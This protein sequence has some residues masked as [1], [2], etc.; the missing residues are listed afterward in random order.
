MAAYTSKN[1]GV[2]DAEGESTWNEAG[3]PTAGDTVTI[4]NGHTVTLDSASACTTLTIDAGGV[5]TDATNNQ[6]L[7]VSG[8]TI[9]N[10]TLTCG[11]GAMSFG[12]GITASFAIT[13]NSGGT[14]TGGSGT[15]VIGSIYNNTGTLT[16][17]SGTTTID[18]ALVANDLS[19]ALNSGTFNHSDGTVT[20]TMADDQLLFDTNNTAR[21]F[22]NL[23]VN[24]AAGHFQFE[25]G[26][27]YHLTVA[28]DL[29]ITAGEFDTKETVS[30]TS[31][32]LTVVGKTIVS[33]TLT[34]NASTISLGS[35]KTQLVP[36]LDIK[37]GGTFNG[38]SGTHT[39]GNVESI[40]A[41]STLTMTSGNCTIDGGQSGTQF[42]ISSNST[43]NHNDGTLILAYPHHLFVDSQSLYNLTID[44]ALGD[45]HLDADLT[46]ANDL[47]VTAGGFETDDDGGPSYDV[48]VGGNVEITS[49]MEC[50]DSTTIDF[51]G[52]VIINVGGLL[53]APTGTLYFSGSI[54]TNN[55]TFS[56]RNGAV[57]FDGNKQ[58]IIGSN[59]WY[60]FTKAVTLADTL[61]IDN[62]STQT[63]TKHVTLNGVTGSGGGWVSPTG[64]ESDS[65]TDSE[66]IY[67]G[68]IATSGKESTSG[69]SVTLTVS[70]LPCDKIRIKAGLVA[71]GATN[72][73]IE[74]Y[75]GSAFHQIHSGALTEDTWQEIAIGSTENIT[76][77]RLTTNSGL[78]SEVWEFEFFDTSLSSLLSIV[79]DSAGDA[80]DF[81][82]YPA[83]LKT[84]LEYLSVKD[85][86]ASGSAPVFKPIAPTNSIDVSGNTDWFSSAPS[87]SNEFATSRSYYY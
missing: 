2:W 59:I 62:T 61:T 13:I 17:T 23:I 48:T 79:S 9:I 6:G 71:G 81:I 52:N 67:D 63:L 60:D 38:G 30:G 54:W 46:I 83:S 76:K 80:F 37:A 73:K 58:K 51:N 18:S 15:H 70:S 74:V 24:K 5:L 25:N 36:M 29:T 69:Q 49:N 42:E 20:F 33:G 26:N 32:D 31:R 12:S 84:K 86:D 27:G 82:M 8:A 7:T 77:A 56:H 57:I 66:N 50:K 44:H 87:I 21:T 16:L 41:T 72:L 28:N 22:Y 43:F 1:T 65:W 64:K 35:G 14:F 68:N 75:Y 39:I 3:H 78:N 55:G 53:Q 40:T 34:C 4:Q 19:I 11:S 85:S 10:G 45:T 47:T